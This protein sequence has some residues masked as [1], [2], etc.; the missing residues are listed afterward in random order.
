MLYPQ[1]GDSFVTIDSVTSLHAVYTQALIAV[2]QLAACGCVYAGSA[3]DPAFV[4]SE[5]LRAQLSAVRP[6]ISTWEQ[7]SRLLCRCERQLLTYRFIFR[8]F[9]TFRCY[10]AHLFCE[11]HTATTIGY[12]S[13]LYTQLTDLTTV[14]FQWMLAFGPT[15]F[16][17]SASWHWPCLV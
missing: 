4:G 9:S 17:F 7:T 11:R 8:K 10:S 1:N 6:G 16:A 3:Y 2:L 14:D 12:S 15:D 5:R 13:F